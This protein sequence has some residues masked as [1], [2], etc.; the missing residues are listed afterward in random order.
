MRILNVKY[1]HVYVYCS[2]V[3]IFKRLCSNSHAGLTLDITVTKNTG[4]LNEHY[5]V[6]LFVLSAFFAVQQSDDFVFL[7]AF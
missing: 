1:P 6:H 5:K 7:T 2:P 3:K 4:H